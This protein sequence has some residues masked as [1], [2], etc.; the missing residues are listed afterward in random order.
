[1]SFRPA[2]LVRAGCLVAALALV[3]GCRIG[4]ADP[5]FFETD[6]AQHALDVLKGK[7]DHPIRALDV[8]I[9]RDSFSIEVQDPVLP[10]HIDKWTY[11]RDR[12]AM[13]DF[14][15][16][17]WYIN[18]ENTSGPTPVELN[19]IN[20]RLE[21]NLF[22][23]GDV[24][25]A[26]MTRLSQAAIK[27]A[28]LEDPGAIDKMQIA[29]Q[30]ILIPTAR[31]G[32]VAW[33]V[34]VRSP[35]ERASMIADA[36]GN[37]RRVNLDG[38]LRAQTVNMYE[39][40]KPLADAVAEIARLW[41]TEPSIEIFRFATTYVWFLA[42][43]LDDATKER[44]YNASLNGVYEP[45]GDISVPNPKTPG[46]PRYEKFGINEV[47]W[48]QLVKLEAAARERLEMPRGSLYAIEVTKLGRDFGP[49]FVQWEITIGERGEKGA[50]VFDTSGAVKQVRLPPSRK[51]PANYLDPAAIVQG[52]AALRK[53]LGE[54]AHVME[55]D[56]NDRSLDITAEDPRKPGTLGGFSYEEGDIR[57][58]LAAPSMALWHNFQDD[59]FF[60]AREIDD[61]LL[62]RVAELKERTLERL[63]LAGGKV[64]RI[65]FS[66]NKVF[67]PLS[68]QLQ[69]IIRIEGDDGKGGWIAYSREGEV[70]HV[71]T[72]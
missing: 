22:D 57:R 49:S 72:P 66:K 11:S 17:D 33:T 30:L 62:A 39:G 69:I 40:G 44:W 24:D 37:I 56:F 8:E 48:S 53:T 16:G 21:E 10:T 68:R 15:L 61:A 46:L 52:A 67:D 25:F 4:A 26:A 60:E 5:P 19:L 45:L 18:W 23:L 55:L 65:T 42:R 7:I 9:S 51:P 3:G 29:R 63:K 28:A 47:D 50:V 38:T 20:P 54:H 27:R 31:S 32:D 12:L 13:R 36:K 70:L 64:D 41:G 6:Q 1:M 58:S 14:H 35:R 59:W 2:R 34:E 43:D 71:M